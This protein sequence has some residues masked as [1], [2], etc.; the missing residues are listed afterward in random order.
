MLKE[1]IKSPFKFLSIL[2]NSA[3][4]IL[5]SSFSLPEADFQISYSFPTEKKKKKKFTD[6]LIPYGQE[7]YWGIES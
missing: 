7:H 5:D 6:E 3:W 4:E 1:N 2:I